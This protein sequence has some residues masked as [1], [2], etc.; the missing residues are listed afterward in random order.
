MKEEPSES[1]ADPLPGP[2][3]RQFVAAAAGVTLGTIAGCS[4]VATQEFEATPMILPEEGRGALTVSEVTR[5]S[6]TVS[7]EV[8]EIDGEVTITSYTAA[9][10]RGPA[11]GQ[12]T[13]I[14]K[15]VGRVNDT[16]G[17]GSATVVTGSDVGLEEVT[18]DGFADAPTVVGDRISLIVP[19][20]ARADSETKPEVGA[21]D[22]TMV[23]VQGPA[24][25]G[26][27][28]TADM[29]GTFLDCPQFLPNQ[30]WIPA[31]PSGPFDPGKR[32]LHEDAPFAPVDAEA[33]FVVLGDA[34]ADDLFGLP[35]EEL[36]GERVEGG[37]DADT[38]NNPFLTGNNPF[39]TGNN[40]FLVAA[41][42]SVAFDDRSPFFERASRLVDGGDRYG[43]DRSPYFKQAS[44][45][46]DA[47]V[48]APLGGATYGVGVLST[49][50]AAVADQSTNPLAHLSFE[51][52]LTSERIRHLY[53]GSGSTL[54]ER[55]VEWLDGPT[56]TADAPAGIVHS[57][58]PDG[59]T[60]AGREAELESFVGTISSDNGPVGIG[61]TAARVET[62]GDVVII[63]GTHRWPVGSAE[64]VA[65][66][67]KR[68]TGI[69]GTI[70]TEARGLTDEVGRRI[71]AGDADTIGG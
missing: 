29:G 32:W 24:L 64:G 2:S 38:G 34:S 62:D 65:G 43:S 12:P 67:G 5:D 39:L 42:A 66:G 71:D 19:I 37:T 53:P 46:M 27:P 56:P 58:S 30:A 44:Q 61:V 23:L 36:P 1:R 7:R 68:F 17:S 49:P 16:P 26:T 15:F 25:E 10:S 41:P 70:F 33:V 14:E 18:L 45:L 54:S 3:R 60:I 21:T 69:L 50:A 59:T 22:E 40:P 6:S 8:E 28:V 48:P 11:R 20:G 63:A 4:G 31:P 55:T 47:G 57:D 52:I 13:L 9:Y 35:P 51:D